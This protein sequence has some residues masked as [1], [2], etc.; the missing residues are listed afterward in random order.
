M[1][2]DEQIKTFRDFIEQNYYPQLLEAVRKG[3]FF[4][5]IDFAELIKFNF[6]ISEETLDNPEELLKAAEMAAKEIVSIENN[7]KL[8]IR[9]LNLPSSLKIMISEVRSKHLNK[10]VWFE[11][12]VRNKTEVRPHVTS[13]KFECPSCGNIFTVI[14]ADTKYKEPTRCSCGRK[15]KFKEISREFVDAQGLVL[16]ENPDELDGTQPK[17]INVF[18]KNDLV[19]ALTERKASPGT[20]DRLVGS[21]VEVPVDLKTGGK[22]TKYEIIVEANSIEALHDDTLSLNISEKDMEEIM[23]IAKSSDPLHALAGSLAPSIHGHEKIKEAIILQLAGGCRK[24]RPD[25]VTTRGDM[26]MLLI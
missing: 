16:E 21:V 9:L 19:S 6:E 26:H 4:L 12:I 8:H 13:A 2:V 24:V 20:R 23:K 11:G 14:Q 5:F 18:L 1:E 15:G 7:K 3:E 17:R 25:G 22:S 10:L